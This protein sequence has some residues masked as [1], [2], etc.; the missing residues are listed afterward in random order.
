LLEQA[1]IKNPDL[2][3]NQLIAEKNKALGEHLEIRSFVRFMVGEEI[4]G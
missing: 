2:T 1:F 3:I 4:A